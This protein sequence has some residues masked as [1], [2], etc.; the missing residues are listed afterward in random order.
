M[1]TTLNYIYDKSG[2]KEYVVIPLS[3]W[4]SI[5]KYIPKIEPRD[6]ANS[7]DKFKP[8]K[9]FGLLSD[10]NL[11]IEQEL[12]EIRQQWTKNI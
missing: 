2:N 12:N 4:E 3:F 6:K 5:K 8:E 9:Y 1:P 11:N 7:K 10:K